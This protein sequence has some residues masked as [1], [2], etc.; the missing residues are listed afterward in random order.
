LRSLPANAGPARTA[1]ATNPH[2]NS[3]PHFHP[4]H[5]RDAARL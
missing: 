4:C 3:F 1:L 2:R 5:I